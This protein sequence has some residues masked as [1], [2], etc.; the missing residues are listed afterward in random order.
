MASAPLLAL[1]LMSACCP[2]LHLPVF[3]LSLS[4]PPVHLTACLSCSCM[5][6]RRLRS[7]PLEL[8]LSHV[9]T[10]SHLLQL[11]HTKIQIYILKSDSH[12]LNILILSDTDVSLGNKK[13]RVH[14]EKQ[15]SADTVENVTVTYGLVCKS[16]LTLHCRNKLLF[17]L[18]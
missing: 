9:F 10:L 17:P 14:R 8:P 2:L 11:L 6:F 18:K 16:S 1:L 5:I 15:D 13:Y 3:L 12:G 4:S 7:P